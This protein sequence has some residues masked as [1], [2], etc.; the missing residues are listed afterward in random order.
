MAKIGSR[1]MAAN[2][3]TIESI[4]VAAYRS[5]YFSSSNQSAARKAAND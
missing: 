3:E 1:E 4:S 2:A 5:S